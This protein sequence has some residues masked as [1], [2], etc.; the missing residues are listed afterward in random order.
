MSRDRFRSLSEYDDTHG[1]LVPSVWDA[2]PG[3]QRA[4]IGG[5]PETEDFGSYG[6]AGTEIA[7]AERDRARIEAL[8]R[9]EED[10]AGLFNEEGEPMVQP[11]RGLRRQIG[12]RPR[13]DI[14]LEE[15]AESPGFAAMM[16]V[17]DTL[18][19]PRDIIANANAAGGAGGREAAQSEMDRSMAESPYAAAGGALVGAAPMM[20]AAPVLGEAAIARMGGAA[21]QAGSRI[22]VL[23]RAGAAGLEGMGWAGL[24]EQAADRPVGSEM[25][26]AGPIAA[27]GTAALA[28]V[29]E[30]AARAP[31]YVQGLEDMAGQWRTRAAGGRTLP[32]QR[33]LANLPGGTQ[34]V[35]D[36]LDVLGISPRYSVHSVDDARQVADRV[37]DRSGRNIGRV[38]DRMAEVDAED[39]AR[40]TREIEPVRARDAD[41]AA[42][43]DAIDTDDPS[44]LLIPNEPDSPLGRIGREILT[45]RVDRPVPARRASIEAELRQNLPSAETV[46]AEPPTRITST[47][48]ET[49]SR[50]R[51]RPAGLPRTPENILNAFDQGDTTAV[52]GGRELSRTGSVPPMPT[53]PQASA[54]RL[55]GLVDQVIPGIEAPTSPG[56]VDLDPVLR[57]LGEIESNHST[58]PSAT[59]PRAAASSIRTDYE[60]TGG[61]MPFGRPRSGGRPGT[62]AQGEIEALD[63]D[64]NWNPGGGG[65]PRRPGAAQSDLRATRRSLRG[66]MDDAV[67]RVDPEMGA[68]YPRQR[69]ENQIGRIFGNLGED[70]AMREA[71]N[72]QVSPTDYIAAMEGDG[73]FTRGRNVLLNRLFRGREASLGAT[74][75]EHLSDLAQRTPD[76]SGAANAVGGRT[77]RAIAAIGDRPEARPVSAEGMSNDQ[78]V[79][80]LEE[81]QPPADDSQPAPDQLSDDEWL[82][83][84]EEPQ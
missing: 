65:M 40:W 38:F 31:D 53:R 10:A 74:G 2:I 29:G 20:L 14:A 30:L 27:G 84:L 25:M 51:G 71:A 59:G 75:A 21:L 42:A 11:E 24:H 26:F 54:N 62:G 58:V 83:M 45:E 61:R 41:R 81:P 32:V 28:G 47:A 43:F 73:W 23:A 39:A 16:G 52:Y 80:M 17:A 60:A 49:P 9:I 22:P 1:G 76:I 48:S 57:A 18:S 72:R 70:N 8:R 67:T 4:D 44:M 68:E 79:E 19:V 63:E 77:G 69:R 6:G 3:L 55:R 12:V 34:G 5:L 46:A 78:W 37:R 33:A 7:A 66:A 13:S 82:D 35:A 64:I 36:D 15:V 56:S 50:R